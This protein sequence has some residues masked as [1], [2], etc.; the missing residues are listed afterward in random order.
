MKNVGD[1]SHV[2]LEHLGGQDARTEAGEVEWLVSWETKGQFL[3]WLRSNLG[4]WRE[5]FDEEAAVAVNDAKAGTSE[6]KVDEA[7]A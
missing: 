7:E 2:L 4:K 3:T 6:A 5:R 1:S